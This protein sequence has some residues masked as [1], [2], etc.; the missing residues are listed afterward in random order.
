[1][2]KSERL[3]KQSTVNHVDAQASTTFVNEQSD[4]DVNYD[5]VLKMPAAVYVKHA[6]QRINVK[7]MS[8]VLSHKRTD[9]TF[10]N[11]NK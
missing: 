4:D 9:K 5:E 1:M 6:Q 11:L 8:S 3:K 7:L 2:R 10:S